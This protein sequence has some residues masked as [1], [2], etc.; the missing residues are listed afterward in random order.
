MRIAVKLGD[1]AGLLCEQLETL[2]TQPGT[3]YSF[4]WYSYNYG[5]FIYFCADVLITDL[6][7]TDMLD[8]DRWDTYLLGQ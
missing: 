5:I 4:T 6:I 7:G 1:L 3:Q 2:G 8:T